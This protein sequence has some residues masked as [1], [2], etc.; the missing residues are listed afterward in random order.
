MNK[1]INSVKSSIVGLITAFLGA[2]AGCDNTSKNW[3]RFLIPFALAGLAYGYLHNFW[4]LT[5]MIMMI[6]FSTGYGIP[7]DND[8]GSALGKFWYK[9]VTIVW[10]KFFTYSFCLQ[11]VSLITDILTRG[12]IALMVNLSLLSIPI[13]K[14][15]WITYLIGCGFIKLAYVTCSYRDL[16]G[17]WV[18]GKYLLI[19]DIIVYGII[20]LMASIM[21]YF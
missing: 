16:G 5:I 17:I 1:I 3:R 7:S 6:A 19:S 21:I 18:K 9:W 8:D 10:Y 20:G 11:K 15:N 14:G 2:F 13:L 4:V 12:M